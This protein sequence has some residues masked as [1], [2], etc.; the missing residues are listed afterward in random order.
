MPGYVLAV[1]GGTDPRAGLTAIVQGTVSVPNRKT[2]SVWIYLSTNGRR[3]TYNDSVLPML[4]AKDASG[5]KALAGVQS[6]VTPQPNPFA[7]CVRR[8]RQEHRPLHDIRDV[9]AACNPQPLSG[10]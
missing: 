5:G 9:I 10:P 3:W 6:K 8:A 2:A 7:Q 1:I 4:G